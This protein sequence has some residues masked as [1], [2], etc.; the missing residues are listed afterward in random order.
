MATVTIIRNSNIG[1]T[2]LFEMMA[3]YM[4]DSNE[5]IDDICKDVIK[6]VNENLPDS[7][8]WNATASELIAEETEDMDEET[9]M[10][11]ITDG[12][13]ECAV[14]HDEDSCSSLTDAKRQDIRKEICFSLMKD[15]DDAEN[16]Y[17]SPN[18][19]DVWNLD[20]KLNKQRATV[21]EYRKAFEDF[22]TG[23]IG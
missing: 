21:K 5:D 20:K 6:W 22:Y 8:F 9:F 3:N 7:F 23:Y 10:G 1:Y 14:D 18:P 19:E 2:N 16:L 11:Y 4:G 17:D 15:T 13:I 12:I